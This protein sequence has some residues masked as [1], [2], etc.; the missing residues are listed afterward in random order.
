MLTIHTKL[1]SII[2]SKI[3]LLK[4]NVNMSPLHTQFLSES[5]HV[6]RQNHT[7]TL[8]HTHATNNISHISHI[9]NWFLEHESTVLNGLHSH[10]I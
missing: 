5:I 10:Q 6:Y 1:V 2:V 9:S 3:R 7:L 8:T 4:F